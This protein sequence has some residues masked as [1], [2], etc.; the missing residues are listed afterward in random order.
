VE[1]GVGTRVVS[2]PWREKF[3]AQDRETITE[4]LPQSTL[5]ISIEAGVTSGWK[6]LVGSD[7][8]TIGIDRFGAS[9]PGGTVMKELGLS[10]E[11][12][13]PKVLGLLGRI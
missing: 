3:L 10:K 2:V 4:I 5:K 12:I 8:I 6:S 1:H 13:V 9:A 7:G 11:A